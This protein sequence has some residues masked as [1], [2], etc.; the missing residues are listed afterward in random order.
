MKSV[1]D[2]LVCCIRAFCSSLIV[3]VSPP[4]QAGQPVIID[5]I[6][7]LVN[8]EVITQSELD[9][10]VLLSRRELSQQYAGEELLRAVEG[11]KSDILRKIIEERIQVQAARRQGVR[12]SDEELTE[13]LQ[14]IQKRN[15]FSDE[16]AFRQA[17]AREGL[18]LS[19][20]QKNLTKQLLLAKLISQEVNAR[21][22]VTER[23]MRTYYEDN[24]EQFIQ[25]EQVR[26]RQILIALPPD[27]N[28]EETSR[29]EGKAQ[30]V[31][32]LITQGEDFSTVARL[33][34]EG[35]ER[36]Q[37]GDLGFFRWR[38]LSP[39]VESALSSLKGGEVSTI[40]RTSSGLH[41]FKIEER[42]K[43]EPRPFEEVK[44]EIAERLFRQQSEE[45]YLKWFSDLR[46]E[47]FVKIY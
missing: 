45:A 5:R 46:A 40:V 16:E 3:L 47:A 23:N 28:E 17:L 34:G 24:R 18:T 14:D 2:I 26:V 10:A 41:I 36:L 39:S 35:R 9:E 27:A 32:G 42:K 43:G 1:R 44:K 15:G 33:Y 29:K 31:L 38:D 12:I 30:E 21:I 37:G 7:A 20:Y 19:Q 25:E 22:I 8:D 4:I 6:V 11:V 13:A